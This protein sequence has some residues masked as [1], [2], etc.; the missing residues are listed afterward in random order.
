VIEEAS[1]AQ[2]IFNFFPTAGPVQA[3]YHCE[4]LLE[5]RSA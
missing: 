1:A 3:F 2:E 5:L 4:E